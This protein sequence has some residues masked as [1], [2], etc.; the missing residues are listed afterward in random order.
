MARKRFVIELGF[1]ADLHGADMTKACVRAVRDAVSRSCLCGL[2]EVHGRDG[3]EGVYVHA[4]LGVPDPG[5]VDRGQVLAAI[6]IGVKSVEVR[7]GGLRLPGLEVPRFGPGVSDIVVACAGIT[8]SVD[9]PGHGGAPSA[10]T[11]R[12]CPAG[13][14]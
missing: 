10:T 9:E 7:P 11:S 2:V 1:G 14:P 8:V 4:D 3:F 13:N 12:D 5:A 6:P